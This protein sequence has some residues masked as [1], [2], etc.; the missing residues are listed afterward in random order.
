MSGLAFQAKHTRF[1]SQSRNNDCQS[2]TANGNA[3]LVAPSTTQVALY[4]NYGSIT[5]SR[6]L[7][8]ARSLL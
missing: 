6:S 8:A 5:R 1:G 4:H 3:P 2:N 7:R